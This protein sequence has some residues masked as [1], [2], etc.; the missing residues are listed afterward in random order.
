MISHVWDKCD[1]CVWDKCDTWDIP[2]DLMCVSILCERHETWC[3]RHVCVRI[4]PI[5]ETCLTHAIYTHVWDYP[6]NICTWMYICS[7]IYIHIYTSIYTHIHIFP[8]WHAAGGVS[9]MG[10]KISHQ[11]S[12][13]RERDI[14]DIACVRQVWHMCVR[15]V[16][17]MGYPM[18]LD[19]CIDR[20]LKIIGLFCKRAL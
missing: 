8:A 1:T 19:V 5:C 13:M 14:D 7:Y 17:H 11:V 6:V 12:H 2:W 9:H 3:V 15:Q 16:W 4:Y 18:R 20:I 10:Y